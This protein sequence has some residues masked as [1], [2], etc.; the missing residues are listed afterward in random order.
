MSAGKTLIGGTAKTIVGGKALVGGT[1]KTITKGKTLIGGTA[2][3]ITFPTYTIAKEGSYGFSIGTVTN[4]NSST[5]D[6]VYESSNEGKNNSYSVAKITFSGYEEFVVYIR[7]YAEGNYDYTIASKVDISGYPT[8]SNTSS[9]VEAHTR[10]N[11]KSGTTISDY[12]KVTYSTDGGEHYIYIV[13]RKDSSTHSNS[14]KGYFLI[15]KY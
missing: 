10:G 2:K 13:Y 12:T 8:S 3:T 4:P 1:A 14:D 9:K 6:G 11:Q 5:Y 7:S 15:E